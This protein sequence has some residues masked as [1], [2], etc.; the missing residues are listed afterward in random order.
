MTKTVMTK[1]TNISLILLL[2]WFVF[3]ALLGKDTALWSALTYGIESCL[4]FLA[5]IGIKNECYVIGW[6]ANTVIFFYA[7]RVIVSVAILTFNKV[8]NFLNDN[9]MSIYFVSIAIFISFIIN[10]RKL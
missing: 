3:F 1:L 10:R 4:L 7:Y 9:S 5:L 2:V 6:V 8:G